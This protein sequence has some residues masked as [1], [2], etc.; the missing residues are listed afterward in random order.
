MARFFSLVL[1]SLPLFAC[2]TGGKLELPLDSPEPP[3]DPPPAATAG[4][5]DTATEGAGG[6]DQGGSEAPACAA[7]GL[8][9]PAPQ[10]APLCASDAVCDTDVDCALH[11][12]TY[13]Q[14]DLCSFAG[15]LRGGCLL[16]RV[17]GQ[18]CSRDGECVSGKCEC[19]GADCVCGAEEGPPDF[20]F[21]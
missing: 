3:V 14:L 5:E 11:P 15:C 18:A 1:I 12:G 21:P 17:Q 4:P 6:A 10:E 8:H 20:S 16:T 2:A 19:A 9:R 13:C 7:G